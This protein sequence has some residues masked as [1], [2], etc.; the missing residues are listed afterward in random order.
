[1]SSQRAF[2]FPSPT[3]DIPATS[4]L[5]VLGRLLKDPRNPERRI[6]GT[7]AI[8][9][10][11]EQIYT[12]QKLDW[13]SVNDQL[14]RG[15][16]G[17]WA[18]ALQLVGGGFDLSQTKACLDIHEFETLETK[19]FVP[20]AEYIS[21]A[22]QDDGVKAFLHATHSR[23]PIYLI[24]GLKIARGAKVTN[25]THLERGVAAEVKVDATGFGAPVEVGPEG[26]FGVRRAMQTSFAGSTDY[27]FAY[28]LERIRVKRRTEEVESKEYIKGAMFGRDD[29]DS[30]D[31]MEFIA[32][33]F[34]E[35]GVEED[36]EEV[37]PADKA[38][39]AST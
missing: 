10:S 22:M 5:V 21:R 23:D 8:S 24:T 1:M 6:P 4:D 28:R 16:I 11:P 39:L 14:K 25:K 7:Q 30:D 29:D 26:G 18:K 3:W 13:S 34:E 15:K 2:Y 20:D 19:Y 36:D 33:E 12:G 37:V 9:P 32:D 17:I 31:E 38:N 35:G 27:I